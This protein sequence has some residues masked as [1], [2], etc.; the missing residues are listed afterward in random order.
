M[1]FD[2]KRVFCFVTDIPDGIPV[3]TVDRLKFAQGGPLIA[4]CIAP[5]S[6]PAANLTWFVNDQRVSETG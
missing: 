3:I 2:G 6:S 4:D 1:L 5:P